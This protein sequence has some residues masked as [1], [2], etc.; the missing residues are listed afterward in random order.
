MYVN[1]FIIGSREIHLGHVPGTP[2]LP[3]RSHTTSIKGRTYLRMREGEAKSND[4]FHETTTGSLLPLPPSFARS[5][6]GLLAAS[7]HAASSLTQNASFSRRTTRI[8][9]T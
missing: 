6:A 2:M 8:S 4:H 5:L 1:V 3:E 9:L 7:A